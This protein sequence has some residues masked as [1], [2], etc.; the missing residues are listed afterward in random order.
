MDQSNKLNVVTGALSYTGKYITARLLSQNERVRTLTGHPD[1]E[2]PFGKEIEFFPYNLDKP[3]KLRESL[4]GVETL[5]NTYW[6]RTPYRDITFEKAV[7]NTKIL[8]EA[9]LKAGV[10]KIVH[11]SVTNANEESDLPYFRGKGKVERIIQESGLKYA[12]LRPALIF[13]REDILINNIA[14]CLRKFPVFGLFGAGEYL[15]QPIY[16]DNLAELA[17]QARD[18]ENSMVLNVAGPEIY[19]FDQLV[20]LIK[21]KIKS[22]CRIL[23]LPFFLPLIFSKMI[24]V[25]VK[26][27]LL[28]K[29]EIRGLV[30]NL[31]YA[32][33]SLKGKTKFSSWL[34]ENQEF[35]GRQYAS[36]LKRHY[37]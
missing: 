17:I 11:I 2:N 19:T 27:I 13:G 1:R 16:V 20:H 30:Q 8:V 14:W 12:I 15:V 35:L 31:L 33:E 3:E 34:D 24:G 4:A 5:Y 32:K 29:D 28:T 9:A 7:A 26:D 37:L 21:E 36:E 25:F 6:I 10:K 23:H 18:S 22:N